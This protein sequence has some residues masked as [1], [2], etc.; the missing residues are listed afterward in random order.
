MTAIYSLAISAR[1]TL[2]LHSLNNE[3][4][5]GNQIQTRMVDVINPQ[6]K[7][8]QVNAI[9]GDMFKHIQV[10][11]LF[12]LAQAGGH[13]LCA[14]CSK[15]DANRISGDDAFLKRVEA[16]KYS[17]VQT[18]DDMLHSC[19]IDDL[20]G[21]LITAGKRSVPRKSVAEF[22]W[23]VGIP[24]EV[25][26]EQYFHVKYNPR[27]RNKEEK[28]AEAGAESS[29]DR[30]SNQGQAIFHRPASSGNYAMISH[31]EVARIGYND[32]SQQYA[33]DETE[34]TTRLRLLLQSLIYTFVQPRG[35]MRNTQLPHL[36]ELQGVISVSHGVLPAPTVSPLN[37]EYQA[38]IEGIAAA[39]NGLSSETLPPGAESQKA[40]ISLYP[41]ESLA[42]FTQQMSD[43][44]REATPYRFSSR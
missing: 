17:N 30:S 41:F 38:Q 6:G 35:A 10:E 43:L 11:H 28:E 20:A 8:S 1:A 19:V 5:E 33:L 44:T 4:G 3:G 25:R 15:F 26:T 37:A 24:E 36:V 42:E 18:I 2:N 22:G 40:T 39:L 27:A 12:R 23:V 29:S 14:A 34:R 9:S 32:I 31:L 7:S 21:I 16:N 13:Q